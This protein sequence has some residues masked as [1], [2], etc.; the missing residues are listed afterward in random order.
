MPIRF[1][2]AVLLKAWD[3]QASGPVAEMISIIATV[4][5]LFATHMISLAFGLR[6]LTQISRDYYRA[7]KSDDA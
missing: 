4:A 7:S 1:L 3:G 2:N 6:A 5:P